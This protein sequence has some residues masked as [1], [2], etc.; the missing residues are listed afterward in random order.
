MARVTLDL[1]DTLH[2]KIIKESKE[3]WIHNGNKSSVVRMALQDFFLHK[4]TR[5]RVD[6]AAEQLR[7]TRRS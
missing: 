1:P 6:E 7:N 3:N 5:R 2:G 4:A